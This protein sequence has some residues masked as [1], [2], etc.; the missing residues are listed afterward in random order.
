M[1]QP[2]NPNAA[3]LDAVRAFQQD[4]PDEATRAELQALLDKGDIA[5]LQARFAAPLTFGTAGLRGEIGAGPARMNRAVVARATAGL[6]M[7]MLEADPKARERGLCIGFDGRRMS[8]ELAE[9][10]AAVAAGCCRVA[11]LALLRCYFF[12]ASF[13]PAIA[14]RGPL[15]V[16]ALVCV[17]CPRT[18]SPLRCRKPR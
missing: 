18:G 16:R 2:D 3:L 9:E 6:C 12:T 7:H 17:L 1:T 8:L 5:A 4:D 11:I 10:T 15:R 14:I 13:L